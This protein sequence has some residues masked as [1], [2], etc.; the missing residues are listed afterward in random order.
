[1]NWKAVPG[2]L[3]TRWGHEIQPNTVWQEYPRPQMIRS[4]WLNLNGLWEYAITAVE[5]NTPPVFTGQILVPY[6]IE[7]ALSGVKQPLLPTERLWY[8]RIFKLPESWRGKRVLL[9]FGAVDWQAEVWVNGNKAGTHQGGYVPFHFDISEFL[10]IDENE[11]LVSVWDPTDQHWQPRGKQ[12][13]KPRSIWYTAVSGIWQTVW[14]EPVPETFIARLKL[15]PDIDQST[16]RVEIFLGGNPTSEGMIQ[17]EVYDSGQLVAR[18]QAEVNQG[19]LTL[20]VPNTKLW[21]PN[22][23]QLYDLSISIPSDQVRSYFA[24]RKFSLGR[25]ALGR[26]RL[27]L[28]NRPL[29]NFGPLDQGYWPDGL[30]TP[31]CDSAMRWELEFIKVMGCNMLRKHVK[32]E[33]ARYYYYADQL[34]LIIWQ[35]MPNGAR[36]LGDVP[37]L[38]AML[39]GY[40]HSDE[41]DFHSSGHEDPASRDGFLLELDGMI[42]YLYNFPSIGVWVPFNEGWGQFQAKDIARRLQKLDPTR[43]VDHASGWFDQGAGDFRSMHIY[44]KP[45]PRL[46]PE[47]DRAAVISEFGGYS[48]KLKDHAWNPKMEFGYRKFKTSQALTTAYLRLLR[49]ELQQLVSGGLSAAIYTQT[50]DVE[51][52]VNGYIT[53]DREVVKMDLGQITQVHH[54]LTRE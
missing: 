3:F 48:L 35:D 50:S 27:C 43:L 4:E 37:N 16:L 38:S 21:S 13:L 52:E 23:P 42:E 18:E 11:L 2:H 25:D 39:L 15:T 28:N 54:E 30:Y 19:G 40:N 46:K 6:A 34:G 22:S 8:R 49:K 31:P 33:P 14:L 24:M 26:T 47:P 12:V 7:S 29:F 41:H 45:L 53:Y 10:R 44:I 32:V 17:A 36:A 51:I 5:N 20:R 1:M 9:H